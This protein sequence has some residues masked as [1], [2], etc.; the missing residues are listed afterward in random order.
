MISVIF[1]LFAAAAY[2]IG[3]FFGAIASRKTGPIPVSFVGH[4]FYAATALLVL[5]F[6]PGTWSYEGI[7]VGFA[8]GTFEAIGFLLFYFALTLG[9]VSIVAPLVSAIYAVVPVA[10]G[11]AGGETVSTSAV[12]GLAI[13]LVAVLLLSMEPRETSDAKASAFQFLVI[14]AIAGIVWGLSTVALDFAPK[15]SGMTPVAIGGVTAFVWLG[16]TLVFTPVSRRGKID[17]ETFLSSAMAGVL[18]T[19]A[20]VCILAA[21]RSGELV[22]VGMLTAL[23][24]L[25]TVL[26]SRLILNEV[27]TKLRWVGILLAITASIL[28]SV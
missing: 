23:Y 6:I 22:I 12:F 20:N 14:A 26:L 4:A 13:A 7:T 19:V 15:E 18:F 16:L 3:D 2:G 28:I 1:S 24:P 5:V 10:I 9:P 17:K 25:G 11:F 27:I 8:T 21:L